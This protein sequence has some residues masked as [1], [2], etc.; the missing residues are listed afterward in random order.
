M[1]QHSLVFSASNPLSA[2]AP[3]PQRMDLEFGE[4][5]KDVRS[6]MEQLMAASLMNE[7]QI[8]QLGDEDLLT[9][10]VDHNLSISAK[11]EVLNLVA[12]VRSGDDPRGGQGPDGAFVVGAR[13]QGLYPPNDRWYDAVIVEVHDGGDR[14]TVDWDD[15]DQAHREIPAGSVRPR[16]VREDGAR[17]DI[18]ARRMEEHREAQEWLKRPKDTQLRCVAFASMALFMCTIYQHGVQHFTEATAAT[19]LHLLRWAQE[20]GD[21]HT[22]HMHGPTDFAHTTISKQWVNLPAHHGLHLDFRLW[23]VGQCG[24]CEG[25]PPEAVVRIDNSEHRDNGSGK[26]LKRRS[27]YYLGAADDDDLDSEKEHSAFTWEFSV[28][29]DRLPAPGPQSHSAA[30]AEVSLSQRHTADSVTLSISQDWHDGQDYMYMIHAVGT[31][32]LLLD[33]VQLSVSTCAPAP[34]QPALPAPVRRSMADQ[35]ADRALA[36]AALAATTA[37]L[38]FW[39]GQGVGSA[40]EFM[41][42]ADSP[43]ECAT[44]VASRRP[45]ANGVSYSAP[46]THMRGCWAEYG[47][48]DRAIDSGSLKFVSA[49]FGDLNDDEIVPPKWAASAAQQAHVC[50]PTVSE[51]D[52]RLRPSQSNYTTQECKTCSELGWPS[53]PTGSEYVCAESDEG[54]DCH[55]E[56]MFDEAETVCLALGA[57]L[58][59]A[60]ELVNLEGSGTGCGHDARRVW[61][62]STSEEST[63]VT[64]GDTERIAVLGRFDGALQNIECVDMES[65]T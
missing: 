1:D 15:G 34:K 33:S 12:A 13:V 64:C 30:F 65:T 62:S 31:Q 40:D 42:Q 36:S 3:L 24:A 27:N 63:G 37:N 48:V 8:M 50:I 61:S 10:M 43:M 9:L 14:Y 56:I 22:L 52:R 51:C 49:F 46:D 54:F 39:P 38:T 5:A 57:R 19:D 16:A 11:N 58:C 32:Q 45:S 28:H 20:H 29:A 25:Q 55:D 21:V 26:T 53:T 23:A 2:D 7:E 44:L 47:M 35:A 41:G 6:P 18:L 4:D 17:G 60:A 59:T